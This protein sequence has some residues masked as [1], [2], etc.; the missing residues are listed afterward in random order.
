MSRAQEPAPTCCVMQCREP[1]ASSRCLEILALRQLHFRILG[2]PAERNPRKRIYT[3]R[4][5][6]NIGLL[7]QPPCSAYRTTRF[8]A[9]ST[10][11][12]YGLAV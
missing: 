10:Q 4:L 1:A 6:R 7:M 2:N 8:A 5:C 3:D 9:G 12:G 11:G